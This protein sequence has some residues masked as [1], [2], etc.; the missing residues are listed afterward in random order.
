MLLLPFLPQDVS[1][2][3]AE[4]Q[5]LQRLMEDAS[6]TLEG[7]RAQLGHASAEE[8]ALRAQAGSL[9]GLTRALL[10]AVAGDS[11]YCVLLR[12][13]VALGVFVKLRACVFEE[14]DAILCVPSQMRGNQALPLKFQ[15]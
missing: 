6:A 10:A 4:L 9:T 8:A 12:C 1:A 2:G 5:R 13:S 14:V 11:I 3:K 7:V 15:Q